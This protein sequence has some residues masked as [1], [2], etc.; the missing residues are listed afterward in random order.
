MCGDVMSITRIKL[1]GYCCFSVE[2]IDDF[3]LFTG[4]TVKGIE[5]VVRVERTLSLL[6]KAFS[7]LL[8]YT[9]QI[10]FYIYIN[11]I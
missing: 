1:N 8:R 2:I 7:N 9:D 5:S 11:S 3:V 10:Y 4:G 6:Y